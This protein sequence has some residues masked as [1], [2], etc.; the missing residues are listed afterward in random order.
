MHKC[1]C[2]PWRQSVGVMAQPLKWTNKWI[3][4][5]MYCGESMPPWHRWGTKTS[6]QSDRLIPCKC[7]PER[8][9]MH[10]FCLWFYSL[11]AVLHQDVVERDMQ[12][13]ECY[14]CAICVICNYNTYFC[15]SILLSIFYLSYVINLFCSFLF[16]YSS[17]CS[18]CTGSPSQMSVY[19][20]IP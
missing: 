15:L 16:L 2:C 12:P 9:I 18:Y 1:A 5:R 17:W 11:R 13:T 6:L 3:H 10:L 19:C 4:R 8:T 14:V 7:S 20:L